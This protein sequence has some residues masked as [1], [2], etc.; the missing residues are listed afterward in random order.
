MFVMFVKALFV[1]LRTVTC[2]LHIVVMAVVGV[3]L[4]LLSGEGEHQGVPHLLL[5]T[6]G[7]ALTE[8]EQLLTEV[9]VA[10]ALRLG[11]HLGGGVVTDLD[12]DFG[13]RMNKLGVDGVGSNL[14]V[15]TL[16]LQPGS[17]HAAT[18]EILHT[19]GLDIKLVMGGVH[20]VVK[21]ILGGHDAVVHLDGPHVLALAGL[22][23][24]QAGP[25]PWSDLGV[26]VH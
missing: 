20:W 14:I 1:L 25:V 16:L 22:L 10:T 3:V 5:L 26:A 12:G 19:V 7:R 17:I 18:G 4:L 6:A 13:V 23:A 11:G 21:Q 8:A 9:D 24:L 15:L 2:H